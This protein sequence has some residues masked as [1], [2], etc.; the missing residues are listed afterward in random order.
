VHSLC[1]HAGT[2]R[3]RFLLLVSHITNEMDLIVIY[4]GDF[5]EKVIGN[6]INYSTFFTSCAEACTHCKEGKYSFADRITGIFKLPDPSLLPVL[7]ED[8][9]RA[10]LPNEL[11]EA[12]IAIVSEIHTDLLL[13]LP[14]ILKDSGSG[15]NAIIVPQ[16]RPARI[17]RLQIEEACARERIEIAFPKPFCELQPRNDQPL[18]KKF[19][20]EFKIG[21]P[22]IRIEVDK[23]GNIRRVDVLRS[24]PC[25][26]TWFVAK[27][28][29]RVEV[30][31][32]RELY[33]RIST[34][35]HSY[36]CTAS[37]EKDPEIG[38]TTLHKAGYIIRT[39]VEE[40]IKQSES[41]DPVVG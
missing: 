9:M 33:E 31:N 4:S 2:F 36:P 25:G 14:R 8:S 20:D 13:E 17:A 28:L 34:A 1:F 22:E 24:V 26:S 38:D 18:I 23:R 21:R 12:D 15:I 16:E 11:P 37:M 19:V 39:A 30:N 27:Q 3:R 10:Y 32:T 41:I 35:H 7:I 6:L 40:G 29:T 5:G